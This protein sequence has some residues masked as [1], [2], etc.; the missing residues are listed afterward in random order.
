MKCMLAD[1]IFPMEMKEIDPLLI[2]LLGE[3][4]IGQL[5]GA[6]FNGLKVKCKGK[7]RGSGHR[8]RNFSLH[9]PLPSVP[10][11]LYH[12]SSLQLALLEDLEGNH[13]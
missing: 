6:C 1:I 4:K 2:P 10:F 3:D 7:D 8:Q 5:R 13:G 12:F 11:S 9:P